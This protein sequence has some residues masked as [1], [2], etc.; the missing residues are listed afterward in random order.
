[1]TIETQGLDWTICKVTEIGDKSSGQK[2][3]Q[4][5]NRMSRINIAAWVQVLLVDALAEKQEWTGWVWLSRV[6]TA[7]LS[8]YRVPTD[9]KPNPIK[10]TR[11]APSYN[12][13]FI[14]MK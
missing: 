6:H 1:M 13:P 14:K 2:M 10:G 8:N 12:S 11:R 5:K 7:L 4:Q 3:E 9:W